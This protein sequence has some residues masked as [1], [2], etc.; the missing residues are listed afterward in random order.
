MKI[1]LENK[2]KSSGF[3]EITISPESKKDKELI[4]YFEKEDSY[5]ESYIDKKGNIKLLI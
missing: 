2:R 3:F 1:K 5:I 4:E